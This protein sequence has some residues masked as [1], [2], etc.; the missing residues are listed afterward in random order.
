MHDRSSRAFRV[1]MG[2][3]ERADAK[4]RETLREQLDQL[5]DARARLEAH[6]TEMMRVRDELAHQDARI[7]GLLDGGRPVRIDALLGWQEQRERVAAQHESMRAGLHALQAEIA[8][9][10]E[11][12]ALTRGAIIRNDARIALCRKRIAALQAQ[13]QMRMDDV[14]DEETEE[15][16]VARML[17]LGRAPSDAMTRRSA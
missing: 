11:A 15:G 13:T 2:R 10:D 3:L 16:V 9:I 4:L 7:D 8:G 14:Q 17:A 1:V 5:D 6:R 12:V